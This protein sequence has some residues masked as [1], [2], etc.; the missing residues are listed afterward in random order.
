[1][2]QFFLLLFF[3]IGFYNIAFTQEENDI[4]KN[5]WSANINFIINDLILSKIPE[6]NII[7]YQ[8]SVES[9]VTYRRYFN[10]NF[11]WQIG[12][13]LYSKKSEEDF[14]IGF[15]EEQS[16]SKKGYYLRTGF[17]K[18]HH[19]SNKVKFYLGADV[20]LSFQKYKAFID[21]GDINA[22]V[23]GDYSQINREKEIGLVPHLGF[24]WQVN[25]KIS[26]STETNVVAS[27]VFFDVELDN[28][29]SSEPIINSN[30]LQKDSEQMSFKF[31][32]PIVLLFNLKF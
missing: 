21:F 6:E 12:V 26:F 29:F 15:G 9:L 2:K 11:V 23:E 28:P 18:Y 19:L 13:N 22:F 24:R 14:V 16:Q 8:A 30:I 7:D 4:L 3:V 1:M 31:Q 17:Q 5:E 10:K 32:S 25:P 20:L 27:Y